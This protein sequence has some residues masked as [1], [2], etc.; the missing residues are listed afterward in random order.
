MDQYLKPQIIRLAIITILISFIL[1][2]L[3]G[4]VAGSLLI[5]K[6]PP[7]GL[8][9]LTRQGNSNSG[10]VITTAQ[11]Q[12]VEKVVSDASPAVVSIIATKDLP[13]MRD[14]SGDFFDF[15]FPFQAPREGQKQG[16]SQQREVGGGSGFIVSSDGLIVT[17][18]HVVDISGADY[19][20]LTNDGQKYPAKVLAKDPAQ[21]IA[22]LKIEK[23]DLPTLSLGNSDDISIGQSVIA[24]GNALGEFRNTVSVGV[25]SGS[26]RSVTASSGFGFQTE[27]LEDVIQ[28]DAAINPG[29]SGGP[30]LNLSGQVIGI[31][32]A[33]AQGAQNIGFALPVNL[34]KK[35]VAQVQE[36]GKISYPFI[37]VRYVLVTPVVKEA[38]NLP[39]D[40]GA[41]ISR[42]ENQDE[43]AV[44]PDGPADKS[45]LKENDIILEAAGKKIDKDSPLAKIIQ[46]HNVGEAITLKVLSRGEEKNVIIT[47]AER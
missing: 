22:I 39:V 36:T 11:E 38:N 35:G 1:G 4:G 33:I 44:V 32:V 21:D 8:L 6:V 16:Q 45:G 46:E 27:Q 9:Q 42:G 23:N 5:G 7:E 17:N 25:I 40:Y 18:K 24:I 2:F 30:L 28:T 47:L 20:V 29:N 10:Q 12:A 26:K 43:P 14:R 15:F 13:A 37:G 19:T 31:N 41:L 34:A 3:G